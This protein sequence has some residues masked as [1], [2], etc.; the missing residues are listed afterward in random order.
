[1]AR[2]SLQNQQL[3]IYLYYH[4]SGKDCKEECLWR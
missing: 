3:V 1:M 4:D 2:S